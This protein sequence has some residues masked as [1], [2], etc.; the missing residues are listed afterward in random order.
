MR[1]KKK[2]ID[3]I[4]YSIKNDEVVILEEEM[5]TDYLTNVV[6]EEK[7]KYINTNQVGFS[8]PIITKPYST[9]FS[10]NYKGNTDTEQDTSKQSL[11]TESRSIPNHIPK[12]VDQYA[13]STI[14]E[15]PVTCKLATSLNKK[16]ISKYFYSNSF[17][18]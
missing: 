9:I 6:L 8:K 14:N 10:L 17:N 18:T 1:I 5:F 3:I 7:N 2:Y 16:V 15:T 4:N 13:P 12:D 11:N